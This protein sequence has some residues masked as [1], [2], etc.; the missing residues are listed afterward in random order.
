M[1]PK[2]R[3]RFFDSFASR[4][5]FDPLVPQNWY[6]I[7]PSDLANE[8]VHFNNLFQCYIY[9][10]VPCTSLFLYVLFCFVLFSFVL[11]CFVLFCYLFLFYDTGGTNGVEPI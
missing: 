8:K 10:I 11:F 7:I 5:G 9:Y 4:R 2:E 6:T 3:R 1:A